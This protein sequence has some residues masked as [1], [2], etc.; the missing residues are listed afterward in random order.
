V[1]ALVFVLMVPIRVRMLVGMHPG[2]VAVFVPVMSVRHRIMAMLV[3][4]LIFAVAA[5]ASSPPLLFFLKVFF[6][7]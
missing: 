7:L 5:H 4:V 3:F 1:A 6:I 2:F